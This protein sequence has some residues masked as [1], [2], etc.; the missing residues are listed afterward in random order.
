MNAW[1][2]VEVRD[3]DGVIVAIEPEMLAGCE[4]DDAAEATIRVA[5]AHLSGF[6]GAADNGSAG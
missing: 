2:R 1:W 3:D 5:I 4:L 6:V